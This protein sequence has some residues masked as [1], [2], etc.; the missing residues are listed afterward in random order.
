MWLTNNNKMA[1]FERILKFD[2]LQDKELHSSC[3]QK[4][5]LLIL[6]REKKPFSFV[7]SVQIG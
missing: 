4:V 1:N 5:G 2:L 6:W 3:T 7:F